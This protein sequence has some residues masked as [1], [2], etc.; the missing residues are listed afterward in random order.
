M[1]ARSYFL[2]SIAVLFFSQVCAQDSI[3]VKK[4]SYAFLVTGSADDLKSDQSLWFFGPGFMYRTTMMNN[5]LT[6]GAQAEFASGDTKRTAVYVN[7]GLMVRDFVVFSAGPALIF[8]SD[9]ATTKANPL[10]VVRF[11]LTLLLESGKK[12]LSPMIEG[13]LGAD[14][15][16]LIYGLK[17]TYVF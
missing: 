10:P 12:L 6:V 17:L 3:A 13:E 7:A 1:S 11:G 8:N 5:M 2:F 9:T 15:Y 4:R 14:S 16:R